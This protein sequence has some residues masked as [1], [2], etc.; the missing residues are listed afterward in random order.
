MSV[1]GP[2]SHVT[3]HYRLVARLES[4]EREVASTFGARAATLQLGAGQL[5]PGI[6]AKLMNLAIGAHAVFDLAPDEAY[7]A[8]LAELVQTISR[9]AFDREC[10]PGLDYAQFRAAPRA[11]GERR[12]AGVLK[13]LDAREV[14]VDFNHPLAGVPLRFEVKVI[15]VL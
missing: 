5:A 2:E 6:E 1:V 4:G 14:V 13:R 12:V 15:G 9:A 3:L 7:G 8:R 10:E 11:Q